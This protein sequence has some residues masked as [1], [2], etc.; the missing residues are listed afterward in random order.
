MSFWC[1]QIFK[2]N[3]QNFSRIPALKKRSNQKKIRALYTT[4]WRIFFWPSY[5]TFLKARAEILEIFFV[6]FL[7]DLKTPRGHFEIDWPLEMFFYSRVVRFLPAASK[8]SSHLLLNRICKKEFVVF[9]ELKYHQWQMK[10]LANI[11][12]TVFFE[13]NKGGTAFIFD[14]FYHILS[15]KSMSNFCLKMFIYSM[16][17]N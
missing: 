13:R 8:I 9:L 1:L 4:N 5:T 12:E 6:D 17:C 3:Q 14:I 11:S 2:K 15:S 10:N 16:K 7:E